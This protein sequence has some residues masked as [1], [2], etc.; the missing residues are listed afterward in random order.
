M[1]LLEAFYY[2]APEFIGLRAGVGYWLV[3]MGFRYIYTYF[4]KYLKCK[5]IPSSFSFTACMVCSIAFSFHQ[6]IIA[7]ASSLA[8]VGVRADHLTFISLPSL[9]SLIMVEAKFSLVHRAMPFL[10]PR[11][12]AII[13]YQFFSCK[14]G[15]TIHI[16]RIWR[17]GFHI[18]FLGLSIKNIICRN[19]NHLCI[20][21]LSRHC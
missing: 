5:F 11:I 6:N 17:V 1:F 9:A 14:L 7:F 21:L 20:Q 12:F 2:Q 19:M 13:Y 8:L 16:Y 4:F 10:L 3:G 15:P 18:C